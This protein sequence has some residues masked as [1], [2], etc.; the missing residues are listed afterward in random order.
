[1]RKTL[2]GVLAVTSVLALAGAVRADV[3]VIVSDV[4]DRDGFNGRYNPDTQTL[5]FLFLHSSVGANSTSDYATNTDKKYFWEN[6][7]QTFTHTYTLPAGFNIASV[8]Y[9]IV[10]F[11]NDSHPTN[12]WRN[13]RL[14]IDGIEIQRDGQDFF[15][16][17]VGEYYGGAGPSFDDGAAEKFA[18]SFSLAQLTALKDGSDT[19][20]L[21]HLQDGEAVVQY[22]ASGGG[23]Y[24]KVAVDY[25]RMTITPVPGA[26]VLG[27]VDLGMIGWLKRRADTK[28]E[29]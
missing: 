24:D 5:P 20:L 12:S 18:V 6:D 7:G 22:T 11:D 8:T 29:L 1:M 25:S 21:T 17:A 23:A 3:N 2:A 10:T 14:S 27:A 4:G 28:V 9:E 15:H 19:S 13:G 26:V 16:D